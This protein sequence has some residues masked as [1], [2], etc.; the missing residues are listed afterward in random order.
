MW[1][2]TSMSFLCDSV[3]ILHVA[4]S[5]CQLR[6]PS[7]CDVDVLVVFDFAA[8]ERMLE[9]SVLLLRWGPVMWGMS[10]APFYVTHQSLYFTI[11]LI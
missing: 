10:L 4:F 3:F 11:H 7:G 2:S 8:Q 6:R 1:I 5:C 9:I